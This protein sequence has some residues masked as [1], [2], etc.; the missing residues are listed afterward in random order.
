MRCVL[1]LIVLD[2][3]YVS[4]ASA[5]NTPCDASTRFDAVT[6]MWKLEPD[7]NISQLPAADAPPSGASCGAWWDVHLHLVPTGRPPTTA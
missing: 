6:N 7:Q 1:L 4:Q 2:L 5:Q 3:W